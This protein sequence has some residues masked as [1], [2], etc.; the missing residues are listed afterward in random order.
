MN[1]V[2]IAVEKARA[3]PSVSFSVYSIGMTKYNNGEKVDTFFSLLKPPELCVQPNKKLEYTRYSEEELKHSPTIAELWESRI[4]SFI[5]ELP[6][7]SHGNFNLDY[8]LVNLEWFGVPTPVLRY[9]NSYCLTMRVWSS[10]FFRHLPSIAEELD[11]SYVYNNALDEAEFFGNMILKASEELNCSTLDE[12]LAATEIKIQTKALSSMS[13]WVNNFKKPLE[14]YDI[15]ELEKL[16]VEL[17]EDCRYNKTSNEQYIDLLDEVIGERAYRLDDNFK[18]TEENVEKLLKSNDLLISAAEEGHVKAQSM[19]EKFDIKR[20]ENYFLID[21]DIEIKLIPYI[22][23]YVDPE[24]DWSSC[25]MFVLC[26][27]K[28]DKHLLTFDADNT[29]YFDR[30][31]NWNT[32]YFYDENGEQLDCFKDKYISHAFHE[33]LD[34]QW[35]FQDII[36]INKVL[37]EVNVLHENYVV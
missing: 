27:P 19:I 15:E 31:D 2:T 36:N 9:F 7:L 33:L 6:I 3:C 25:F 10:L 35:C 32:A 8:L 24:T 22:R 18:W 11:I 30:T 5:D 37:V 23:G 29:Q 16:A 4:Y 12:L 14:N 26:E 13:L 34:A 1:F 21:Y 28:N 20:D 17:Y